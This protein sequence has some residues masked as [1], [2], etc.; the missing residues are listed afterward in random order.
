MLV[1]VGVGDSKGE[2]LEPIDGHSLEPSEW[3]ST[4]T[5]R[6]SD[7]LPWDLISSV[8]STSK[9]LGCDSLSPVNGHGLVLLGVRDERECSQKMSQYR[10]M[11]YDR[12]DSRRN[13]D[14]GNESAGK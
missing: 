5:A 10:S 3:Q 8:S 2:K 4:S 7:I 6:R 13:V 12:C 14:L 1:G 9:V 11:V